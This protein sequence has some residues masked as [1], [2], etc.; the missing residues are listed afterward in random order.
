[1]D[2]LSRLLVVF[3]LTISSISMIMLANQAQAQIG[4]GGGRLVNDKYIL[5][6]GNFN[7]T[8]GEASGSNYGLTFTGGQLAQGFF[9]GPNFSV[10]SGFQYYY[11]II[12]FEFSI[13]SQFVDFGPLIPGTPVTRTNRLILSNGSAFGYDVVAYENNA[14]RI[15]STGNDIPDTT[16]DSGTCSETTAALWSQNTTYGFGYRCDNITGTECNS[17]FNTPD[18]Y[19]Q[20]S[21][22]EQNETPESVMGG[23]NVGEDFETEITYKV[24]VSSTQPAGLY[25]NQITYIA[26]PSI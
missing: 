24:N 15:V 4:Q 6:E 10:R 17:G 13:S 19:K 12:P 26:T 3:G 7:Y 14:L 2:N 8:S 5:H 11:S 21:N 20:F 18:Y 9:S 23:P 1:M 25:Q 16:C 22:F